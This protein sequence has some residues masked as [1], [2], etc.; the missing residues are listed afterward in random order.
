VKLFKPEKGWGAMT[1][2][3]LP[4]GMAFAH[5]SVIEG[6][7]IRELTAGEQLHCENCQRH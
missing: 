6:G 5:F 1:S 7:G 2:P 3:D 4:E